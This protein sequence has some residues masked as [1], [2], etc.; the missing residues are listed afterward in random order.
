VKRLS[1]AWVKANKVTFINAGS[2]VGTTLVTS[3]LGFGYWWVAARMFPPAAVGFASAAT[4]A[5]MLLGSVCILGLG[6]LLTG[7]LQRHPGNEMSLINAALLLVG[8]VGG[9]VGIVFALIAPFSSSAFL[10][11]RASFQDIL[12]FAFG[13]SLT[14]ITLVLDQALIGLLRGE[15][16]FWRNILFSVIKLVALLGAGL[17]L[18]HSVNLNIYNT[19]TLGNV[20]SLLI[21]AVFV[22]LKGGSYSKTFAP[23]WSLLRQLKKAAIQHHILNLINQAPALALPLLVAALLSI[24]ANAWFYIAW[25]ITSFMSV[26]TRSL[27]TVL[28]AESSAQP[29]RLAYK[30]R[31]TIGIAFVTCL[32]ANLVI[33]VGA[34]QVLGVFGQTYAEQGALSLRILGLA[35]FPSIIK[36][37]YIAACR[38]QNRL[39]RALLP[40]TV[41]GMLKLGCVI[42]GAYLGGLPGL[43]LGWLIA[44]TIEGIYMAGPVYRILRF[45]D[46]STPDRQDAVGREQ[47]AS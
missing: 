20:L 12:L 21:L 42:V 46:A 36:S 9:G 45:H 28:Y 23:Q 2:L 47:C 17:W 41:F 19:W 15:V 6:T 4:S 8:G 38:I 13:V 14:T 29:A 11:L 18:S 1:Y 37:Y 22:L 26:G 16:Q 34:K 10:P 7:E 24:E 32:L 33:Q 35:A 43:S 44:L 30:A 39:K 27:A 5:M 3:V 40:L 31:L 25:M